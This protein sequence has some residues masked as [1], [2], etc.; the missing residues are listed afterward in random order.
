MA[1]AEVIWAHVG[2]SWAHRAEESPRALIQQAGG[3]AA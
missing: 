1:E 2:R 3:P